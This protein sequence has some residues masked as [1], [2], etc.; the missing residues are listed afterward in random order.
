MSTLSIDSVNHGRMTV[1]TGV[2]RHSF[3]PCLNLN[4]F[5]KL[6][7]GE[8]EAMPKAIRCFRIVLT[9]KVMW[10]VAVVAGS[11][12]VVACLEPTF[13]L[14]AHDVAIHTSFGVVGEI[15]GP[16]GVLKSVEP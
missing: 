2:F 13:I 3:V 11:D 4:R 9:H 5:V 14:F 15:G 16:L 1:A 10:R 7:G 6:S 12:I 8:S